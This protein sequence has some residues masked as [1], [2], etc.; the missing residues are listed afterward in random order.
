VVRALRARGVDRLGALVLTHA[1]LDHIGGAGSVLAA[2]DVDAIYDPALPSG[3]ADYLD[4]LAAA[5]AAAIPWIAA[6]AG[7]VLEFDGARIEVLHPVESVSDAETNEAS[8]ILRVVYGA[9]DALLTG[10]AYKPAERG[11]AAGL[12]GLELLKLGHHGSDTSTD[13]LLLALASPELAI[14]SVGRGNRYGH[15]HPDVLARLERA[16]VP[17]RRTDEEGTIS[18]TGRRDGTFVV[19]TFRSR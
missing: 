5:E 13:S 12:A 18:V 1:D 4:V 16:G 14:V 2:F 11:L 8:V 7:T 10:D 15:P 17:L 9:F 3:K 6:R 19:R